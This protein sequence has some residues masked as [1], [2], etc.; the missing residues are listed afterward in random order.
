MER[1]LSS[2]ELAQDG[3]GRRAYVAWLEERAN[4]AGAEIDQEAMQPSRRGWYL[5]KATFKNR[6]SKLIEKADQSSGK[7]RN[8]TGEA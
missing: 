6:L 4:K 2:F 8:R 3:R 7:T 5:G 1:V